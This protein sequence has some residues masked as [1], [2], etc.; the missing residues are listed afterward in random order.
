M[1]KETLQQHLFDRNTRLYCVLD[2]ASVPE[3][4]K[5]LYETQAPNACLF[6]GE[7]APD[8]LYVAPYVVLLSPGNR[9]TD[10]I[11][12]QGF[13]KHWGI[14]VHCRHSLKEMRRHFRSLVN[15]YD[16]NANSFVFR[17]YDPRVMGKYLSTCNQEELE[18]FFGKA[19][20]F[21]AEEGENLVKYELENDKL[22]Q[23]ELN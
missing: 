2:G 8:M 13:G 16:E 17:F 9:L 22:K 18:A 11:F 6:A 12:S 21:F 19:T 10:L 3:L 23:I 7:L 15:V 20:S 5:R 4:P 14:F 1:N